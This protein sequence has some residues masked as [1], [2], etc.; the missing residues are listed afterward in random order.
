MFIESFSPRFLTETELFSHLIFYRIRKHKELSAILPLLFYTPLI[1][2]GDP[3]EDGAPYLSFQ[4]LLYL[5]MRAC[6][7]DTLIR[8]ACTGDIHAGE[9]AGVM[10][11]QNT[12]K[13]LY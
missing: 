7:S 9:S 2:Y 5:Q 13:S 10:L 3:Y 1:H 11:Y 6:S 12:D 8:I 4:I